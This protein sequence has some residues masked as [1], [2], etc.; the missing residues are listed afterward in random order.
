M[1]KRSSVPV[2]VQVLGT[3]LGA[4][5]SPSL[6]AQAA[7][8]AQSQVNIVQVKPEMTRSFREYLLN[9]ANPALKKSGVTERQVWTTATFGQ[10]SE[11]IF[12]TP[13]QKL[14]D[15]DEPTPLQKALG[16]DGMAALTT[17]RQRHINS[18][19]T[20][21]I[22]ARPELGAPAAPGYQAKLGVSA[23]AIVTPGHVADFM[24]FAREQTAVLMKTTAKGVYVAQIGLG[25]NPNEFITLVLFDSFADIAN[26][27]AA[28][29]K[30]A[31]DAKLQPMA[32]GTVV[33]NEWRVYR[34]AAD[35]SIIPR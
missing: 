1:Q 9:D 31:A 28:Y 3:L 19:T 15:F 29:N 27:T 22:T 35:L 30:A 33:N 21:L 7:A 8:P 2:R 10:A 23:R 12:V 17:K 5:W 24:K 20:F 13:V 16:P 25:G 4:L 34:Y 6:F 11:Y 14:T 32:N 26:F 18:A